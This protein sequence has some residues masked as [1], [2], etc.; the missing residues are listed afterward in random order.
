MILEDAELK[1]IYRIS[2]QE[3]LQA[4]EAGILQLEQDP[5][6][7]EVIE[8]LLREAHSL[9]GDSR[10]VGVS[11]ME[12]V[13]HTLEAVLGK[14]QRQEVQLTEALSDRLYQT[15]DG[16]QRLVTEALTG[17]PNE[18]DA[19]KLVQS[20]LAGSNTDQLV[21]Q[22]QT[23]GEETITQQTA[24]ESSVI[25]DPELRD[26]Y[27]LS[28]Q[29]RIQTLEAGILQLEQDPTQLEVIE[30]LLREA[31]SLKGDSR[32]VGVTTMEAVT[33]ILEEVL[34]K[35]QRQEVVLTQSL[36]DRL[37]QTLDGMQRLV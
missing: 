12:V 29:E 3:R 31:H 15:L 36:S 23:S 33:H 19:E 25:E 6:Q 4:L 2:S 35:I 16:M 20:L 13:T 8:D 22:P 11:G 30:D 27:R 21:N 32:V 17:E 28:S 10:V 37:Y 14:I 5:T 9:K 34:G 7:L 18:S 26:I 24:I 1:E